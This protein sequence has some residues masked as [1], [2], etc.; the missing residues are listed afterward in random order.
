MGAGPAQRFREALGWAQ[1]QRFYKDPGWLNVS[2][3]ENPGRE[4]WREWEMLSLVCLCGN[5]KWA[6]LGHPRSQ[7]DKV[8]SWSG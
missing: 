5:C 3:T 2:E 8:L 4:V 7:E 6:A 1:A